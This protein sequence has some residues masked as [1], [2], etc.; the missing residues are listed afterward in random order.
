ME[1]LPL[2]LSPDN[3]VYKTISSAKRYYGQI[4]N[5]LLLTNPGENISHPEYGVGLHR[6][7]FENPETD[8]FDQ[9]IEEISSQ[10]GTYVS[11]ISLHEVIIER[12]PKITMLNGIVIK[13]EYSI[14]GQMATYSS[15]AY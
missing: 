14:G 12:D 4:L 5:T 13:I 10:I 3:D 6:Y 8:I 9:L 7:V 11:G 2:R 15:S 1:R